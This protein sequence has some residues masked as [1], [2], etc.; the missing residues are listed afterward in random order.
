[1]KNWN[2]APLALKTERRYNTIAFGFGPAVRVCSMGT[3]KNAEYVRAFTGERN[4]MI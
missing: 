2:T 1:M 3:A 4:S